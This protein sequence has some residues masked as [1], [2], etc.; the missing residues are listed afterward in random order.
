MNEADD[1]LNYDSP[2]IK[3]I[4]EVDGEGKETI[5]TYD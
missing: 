1:R 4:L 3:M 5:N 2:Q